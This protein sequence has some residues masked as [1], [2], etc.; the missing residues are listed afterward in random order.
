MFDDLFRGIDLL[1]AKIKLSPNDIDVRQILSSFFFSIR[2]KR[3]LKMSERDL[4]L[5]S[6]TKR[7][8]CYDTQNT[9]SILDYTFCWFRFTR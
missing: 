1:P 5:V 3:E 8:H 4:W 9:I 6:I 7:R 2:R